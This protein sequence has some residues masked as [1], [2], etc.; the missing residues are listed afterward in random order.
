MYY[1]SRSKAKI[2][3]IQVMLLLS[4][5]S[6]LYAKNPAVVT[7]ICQTV[8]DAYGTGPKG[9]WSAVE[10]YAD[11]HVEPGDRNVN[12]TKYSCANLEVTQDTISCVSEFAVDACACV[13]SGLFSTVNIT[14]GALCPDIR[15]IR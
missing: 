11:L 14:A 9:S 12:I 2:K 1:F 4:T 7:A 6:E 3:F 8:C 13:I 5:C 15:G 10:P